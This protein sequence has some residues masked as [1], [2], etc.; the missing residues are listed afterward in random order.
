[1]NERAKHEELYKVQRDDQLLKLATSAAARKQWMEWF[2]Q[3]DPV[4]AATIDLG[5][6]HQLS[7]DETSKLV[8]CVLARERLHTTK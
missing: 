7:D 1:M 5:K 4:V 3:N 8:I 6:A 2:Y